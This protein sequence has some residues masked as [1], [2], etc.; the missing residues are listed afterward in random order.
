MISKRDFLIGGAC[1]GAAG[2][3]YG[4]T[5]RRKLVL[6]GNEKMETIIPKAFGG[7]AS[8]AAAIMI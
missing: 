6:L 2:L 8:A 7:W 4:L 3:A 1:L 5:P